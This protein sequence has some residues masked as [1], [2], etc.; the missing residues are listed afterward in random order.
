MKFQI[1]HSRFLSEQYWIKPYH[2]NNSYDEINFFDYDFDYSKE[3][4]LKTP[5]NTVDGMLLKAGIIENGT[6]TKK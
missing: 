6:M 4:A 1:N 3:K 5:N 2:Y